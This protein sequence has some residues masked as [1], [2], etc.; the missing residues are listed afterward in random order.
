MSTFCHG[1][2]HLP[3][4]TSLKQTVQTPI[5]LLPGSSVLFAH[6][7]L[8]DKYCT[9][10]LSEC[11]RVKREQV[12][13]V[14]SKTQVS[15]ICYDTEKNGKLLMKSRSQSVEVYTVYKRLRFFNIKTLPCNL[16]ALKVL[17]S[18]V[19]PSR[20]S[21]V[22]F[23]ALLLASRLQFSHTLLCPISVGDLEPLS[24]L[25]NTIKITHTYTERPNSLQTVQTHI[26]GS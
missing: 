3:I 12:V 14:Y 5:R 24:V 10:G 6:K 17:S 25:K 7:L 13:S 18:Q 20:L 16:L 26:S 4:W 9:Q 8:S 11:N 15:G 2:Q 23:F 21:L 22:P 1:V 19:V